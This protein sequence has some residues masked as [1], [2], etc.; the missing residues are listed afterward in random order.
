[1]EINYLWS[2]GIAIEVFLPLE[3]LPGVAIVRKNNEN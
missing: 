2:G 3:N 1:M